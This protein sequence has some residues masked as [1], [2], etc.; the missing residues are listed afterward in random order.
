MIQCPSPAPPSYRQGF[1]E[2][3]PDCRQALQSAAFD[4][5]ASLGHL[6]TSI[7]DLPDVFHSVG[8]YCSDPPCLCLSSPE[9]Q[10]RARI[11]GNMFTSCVPFWWENDGVRPPARHVKKGVPSGAQ[12][13]SPPG[14]DSPRL[15]LGRRS[16]KAWFSL[17]LEM[18]GRA[19]STHL[20]LEWLRKEYS[21][22]TELL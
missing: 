6:C 12:L 18:L 15:F 22:R 16:G 21:L 13:G 8:L 14:A 19:K 9:K 3:P 11:L 4:F 20:C 17:G 7:Q 5:L 2:V 10:V 1:G